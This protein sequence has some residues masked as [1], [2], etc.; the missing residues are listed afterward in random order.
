[1]PRL[2]N[3]LYVICHDYLRV[4]WLKFPQ[5]LA[6]LSANEQR[7][8]Q[9]FFAPHQALTATDLLVH[10]QR[11]TQAQPSLPQCAGRAMVHFDKAYRYRV[12]QLKQER[13]SSR[14]K[15]R[16][17]QRNIQVRAVLKA[18]IDLHKLARAL[19]QQLSIHEQRQRSSGVVVPGAPGDAAAGKSGLD[20][21]AG[22]T[23]HR[24]HLGNG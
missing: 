9:T 6:D 18:P 20:G 21:G 23:Q 3:K 24:G 22:S 5:P 16:T 10:R 13:R 12:A 7:Y 1:M 19:L 11:V 8:L 14:P 2:T 17:R 4:A 15:S